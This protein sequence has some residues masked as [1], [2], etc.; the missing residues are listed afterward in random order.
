M[1]DTLST[2]LQTFIEERRLKGLHRKRF[3]AADKHQWIDFSCN[4]YLSLGEE[5]QIKQAYETGVMKHPVG[6]GGSPLTSGYHATHRALETEFAKVL[7]TED[8]LY[9]SSGFSANL[10][11]MALF[12][13]LDL[14]VYLDKAIHAS[15]YDGVSL[16]KVKFLRYQ[17]CDAEDLSRKIRPSTAGVILT[18]SVFSMSGQVSPLAV[19]A[20]MA[21][22]SESI[23]CVDEAHSFGIMGPEG[24][25]LVPTLRLIKDV[26]PLRVI[27]LGK[28]FAAAG[29]IVAGKGIW[30]DAL[31]QLA[32]PYIYSTAPSPAF[33]YGL[34]KT[35]DYIRAAD[36]RR[37]KLNAL[38][39]YFR[40]A[41]SNSPLQWRPS[42]TAIQQLQIGCP[43]VT[44]T[45]HKRLLEKSII[46]FPIRYPTVPRIETGL[47][48]ILNYHHEPRDIDLLLGCLA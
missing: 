45:I 14:L 8:A 19:L 41:I 18:E 48:V 42:H 11:L 23:L 3:V 28:G 20:D 15:I 47:R 7:G 37:S 2:K 21:I 32:R 24:L 30:I 38:I 10:S 16:S 12:G 29:A 22:Q 44:D 34:L 39:A 33:T 9:F 4:D 1:I 25:G 40:E 13:H 5:P 6:S 17:H 36:E 46:C 26:I 31:I 43:Y 27:P 35:L